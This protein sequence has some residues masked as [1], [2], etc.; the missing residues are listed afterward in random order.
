MNSNSAFVLGGVAALVVTRLMRVIGTQASA[1]RLMRAIHRDLADLAAGRSHPTRD[2]WASRM[3][4]RVALLLY[5]QPRFEPRP[6]HEFADAL[7]D[8]RLGVNMIETQSIDAHHV[9]A[10]ARCFGDDV[11]DA[12][13]SISVLLARGRV[14]QLGDDLLQKIDIAISE[15]TACTASTHACIAA[16]VGLR[17]TLYPDAPPYRPRQTGLAD[18]AQIGPSAAAD[19]T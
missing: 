8:L 17:Q 3:M 10:G 13:P 15:V 18:A 4:D 19:V 9:E 7:E 5:R 16:I 2:Q 11:R 1:R 12:S 6:Q 14:A